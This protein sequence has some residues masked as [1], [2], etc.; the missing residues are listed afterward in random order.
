M[1]KDVGLKVALYN[2]DL[3][4]NTALLSEA[5][6]P[7]KLLEKKTHGQVLVLG[8]PEI[9]CYQARCDGTPALQDYKQN[10]KQLI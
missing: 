3:G 7:N 6:G 9:R 5:K 8:V 2:K 10:L 4:K 1:P